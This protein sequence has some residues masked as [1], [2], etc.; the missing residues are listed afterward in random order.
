M[1]PKFRNYLMWSRVAEKT[2]GLAVEKPCF[3]K[4]KP[5]IR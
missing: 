4:R 3:V 2:K 5:W 1:Y